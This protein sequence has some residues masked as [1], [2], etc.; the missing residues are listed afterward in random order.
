[1][2]NKILSIALAFV[3]AAGVCPLAAVTTSADDDEIVEI[4][5]AGTCNYD[6]ANEVAELVNEERAA[7]GLNTLV[8]DKRLT[9]W[10]MQRA[11]EQAFYF[12]H[13]RPD[14]TGWSTVNGGL[15]AYPYYLWFGENAAMGQTTPTQVMDS[16]MNSAGHKATLMDEGYT[17]VGVGC[18][19]MGGYTY[20]IQIFAGPSIGAGGDYEI[21]ESTYSGSQ[22][23]T[24]T[25]STYTSNLKYIGVSYWNW[26]GSLVIG[27]QATYRLSVRGGGMSKAPGYA[28]V[29]PTDVS[30]VKDESTGAVI[31]TTS[32]DLEGNVTIT[33]TAA[34][35]GYLYLYPYE[36]ASPQIAEIV[37][38]SGYTVTFDSDGGSSVSSQTVAYNSA[39]TEP[40]APSKKGYVFDGW[41]A[42]VDQY[43]EEQDDWNQINV[44][45]DFSTPVTKDI[46]LY[47]SWKADTT[48]TTTKDSNS[49]TSSE[50]IETTTKSVETTTSPT[51]AVTEETTAEPDEETAAPDE[52]TGTPDEETT[53]VLD[54]E[55]TGE[56]TDD[57]TEG[58]KTDDFTD[59]TGETETTA[60]ASDGIASDDESNSD[61][62]NASLKNDNNDGNN[63]GNTVADKENGSNAWIVVLVVVLLVA[64]AGV[65]A[66]IVLRR[67]KSVESGNSAESAET[68]NDNDNGEGETDDN[69][70]G[71][72][73]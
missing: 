65:T 40:T 62:D 33:A 7:A 36:G 55:T 56:V 8:N 38:L 31:A 37:V 41:Y 22:V 30:D 3:L 13:V 47:A 61:S 72:D 17:A 58:E 73:E 44:T 42:I 11:A 68:E 63:N 54:D 59:T 23:Q 60:D 48:S 32:V 12:G 71:D 25:I 39:A 70:G 21:I 5:T 26:S 46:T 28:Y 43:D 45:Y 10:A 35:T 57:V 29:V 14:G 53:G 66:F 9:E 50:P 2:R 16:W 4:T 18:V 20:W 69:M 49:E 64:A 24:F 1:M 52:T 51:E 27:T 34:G 15:S 6:Y 19:K 67:N